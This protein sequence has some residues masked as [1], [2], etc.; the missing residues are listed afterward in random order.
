[1]YEND[2][3]CSKDNDLFMSSIVS[4]QLRCFNEK[5]ETFVLWKNNRTLT[6]RYCRPIMFDFKKETVTSTLLEVNI[7]EEQIKQ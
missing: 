2:D 5:N 6:T 3:V 1:M 7:I 4:L